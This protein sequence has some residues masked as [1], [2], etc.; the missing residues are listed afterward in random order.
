LPIWNDGRFFDDE[1]E[2]WHQIYKDAVVR[3]HDL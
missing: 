1:R 2:K 3:F